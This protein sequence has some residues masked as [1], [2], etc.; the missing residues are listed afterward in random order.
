[1]TPNARSAV[2]LLGL[3]LGYA[4]GC[5]DPTADNYV[6]GGVGTEGCIYAPAFGC[7]DVGATNYDGKPSQSCDRGR[8]QARQ[9]AVAG[10]APPALPL[11]RCPPGSE[12]ARHRQ[13]AAALPLLAPPK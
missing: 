8:T 6:V 9:P 10:C 7:P 13:S 5:A 2:A 12:L 11:L 1:M 3:C 4:S